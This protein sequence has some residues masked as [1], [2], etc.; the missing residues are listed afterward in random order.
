MGSVAVHTA[1][2]R[3]FIMLEIHSS[4]GVEAHMFTLVG[5]QLQA[6][7]AAFLLQRSTVSPASSRSHSGEGV[8]NTPDFFSTRKLQCS[9][10]QHRRASKQQGKAKR[11]AAQLKR[12]L[13][14]GIVVFVFYRLPLAPST[15][16]VE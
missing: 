4:I 16:G 15:Y 12:M 6:A 10:R 1:A 2:G 11:Q 14:M 13:S 9:S 7:N 8:L 3:R 5:I